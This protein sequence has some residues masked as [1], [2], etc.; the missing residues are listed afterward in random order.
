MKSSRVAQAKQVGVPATA[1]GEN[2]GLAQRKLADTPR[3]TGEAAHIAQ[4]K[5]KPKPKDIKA[6]PKKGK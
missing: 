3:Q 4:L 1:G 5:G 6:L 2:G